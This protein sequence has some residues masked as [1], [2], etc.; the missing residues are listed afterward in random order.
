MDYRPL[1]IGGITSIVIGGM[2]LKDW[3]DEETENFDLTLT[4][5]DTLGGV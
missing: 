4:T 2:I 3:L 1:I 5:E